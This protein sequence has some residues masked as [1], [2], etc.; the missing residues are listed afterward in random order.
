MGEDVIAYLISHTT[1]LNQYKQEITTDTRTEIYAQLFD[2]KRI[3]FYNAGKAG[4]NPKF[5]LKVAQIDYNGENEIELGEKRYGIYRT[6]RVD[7]D[8][9]ELYCEAKGGV[10]NG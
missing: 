9:I 1:T 10:Q 4:L 8:Y 6:Y 2:I 5:M 3:E 7:K